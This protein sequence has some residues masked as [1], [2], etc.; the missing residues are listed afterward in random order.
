MKSVV[1]NVA[2]EDEEYQGA[3]DAALRDSTDYWAGGLVYQGRNRIS[4]RRVSN[5]KI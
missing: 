5:L 3:N 2:Y 1:I 4:E